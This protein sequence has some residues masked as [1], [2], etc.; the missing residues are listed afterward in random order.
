MGLLTTA[1]AIDGIS[2]GRTS[3]ELGSSWNR[4]DEWP[5]ISRLGNVRYCVPE[6]RLLRRGPQPETD[7]STVPRVTVI[8]ATLNAAAHVQEA[9][10]SVVRQSL[11]SWEL[12]VMDAGSTD[13][14]T[15]RVRSFGDARIQL[16]EEPDEGLAHAW[17]NALQRARGDYVMYLCGDD[18]YTDA[19]WLRTCVS[20][21]ERDPEVSLVWGV[22]GILRDGTFSGVAHWPWGIYVGSA[23]TLEHVQKEKWFWNWLRYG[24]YFSDGNM[25]VR[26]N[27]LRR[28]MPR[29]RMGSRVTDLQFTFHY[30]FNAEGFLPY[31]VPR[32]VSVSRIQE[33]QLS[34]TTT[35]ERRAQVLGYLRRVRRYRRSLLNT[36]R[37]HVFRDGNGAALT[38]LPP[39]KGSLQESDFR[40]R[41][42]DRDEEIDGTRYV[43]ELIDRAISRGL[44]PE[45]LEFVPMDPPACPPFDR[46]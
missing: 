1:E 6:G 20:V 13:G 10:G 45:V 28:C 37:Q 23:E 46:S 24:A 27:V 26:R 22:P 19:D 32:V 30:N 8:M 38:C 2:C 7:V 11:G 36:D 5:S 35:V 43:E 40:M 42:I 14:T 21:M 39:L 33:G 3:A 41:A 25:C 12:L 15:E 4:S 44:G 9:V 31:G 16:Y 18:M 29:Y 17:D 34:T